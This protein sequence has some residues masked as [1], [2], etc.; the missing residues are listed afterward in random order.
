MSKRY[1]FTKETKTVEGTVLHR[2]R[3]N[4]DFWIPSKLENESGRDEIM[5]E[6][7]ALTLVK[8]GTLGGWIEKEENLKQ[9]CLAW[10]ADEACVYGDACVSEAAVVS[11]NATIC[12]GANIYGFAKVYDNAVVSNVSSIYGHAK[13]YDE[14]KVTRANICDSVHIY[15]QADIGY[16]ESGCPIFISHNAKVYE[17]AS[18]HMGEIYISGNARVHGNAVIG[19]WGDYPYIEI[20]GCANV[21]EDACI[22]KSAVITGN[23]IVCGGTYIPDGSYIGGN[24]YIA[25]TLLHTHAAI[26]VTGDAYITESGWPLTINLHQDNKIHEGIITFFTDYHGTLY[27]CIRGVGREIYETPIENKERL[28]AFI[29]ENDLPTFLLSAAEFAKSY[30]ATMSDEEGSSET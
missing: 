9:D 30:F 5:G 3:A 6:A 10:V 15:G 4:T 19:D 11:G 13:I 22:E 12:G 16:G 29:R 2:I 27:M 20:C 18:I 21:H 8:A 1:A 7:P 17:S 14:A 24:A 23:A 26:C 25:T 28:E